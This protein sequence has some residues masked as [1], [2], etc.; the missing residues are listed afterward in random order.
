MKKPNLK[1]ILIII[2][3]I[4]PLFAGDSKSGGRTE[5]IKGNLSRVLPRPLIIPSFTLIPSP[6]IIPTPSPSPSMDYSDLQRIL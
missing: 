5:V 1:Y 2:I 4:I 3:L 6:V